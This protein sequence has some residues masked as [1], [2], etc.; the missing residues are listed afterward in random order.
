[1]FKQLAAVAAHTP[2]HLAITPQ[3]GGRLKVIVT[4]L[5]TGKAKDH[6]GLSKQFSATGTPEEL[7]AEFI[8]A[9]EQY[10]GKVNE[11]RA[12][13]GLPL[14][15]LDRIKESADKKKAKLEAKAAQEAEETKKREDAAKK[16]AETRAAKKAEEE[17]K[18]Q[19]AAERRAAKKAEKSKAKA[20][21]A[22]PGA[23]TEKADAAPFWPF[24]TGAAPTG[25]AASNGNTE[26]PLPAHLASLPGKPEVLA[27][28][29]AMR[30][31]HGDKA[32]KRKFFIK[33]SETGR[34]YEKLWETWADFMAEVAQ[35]T[36]PLATTEPVAATPDPEPEQE[37]GRPVAVLDSKSRTLLGTYSDDTD[38]GLIISIDGRAGKFAVDSVTH[39]VQILAH[40]V[41]EKPYMLFDEKGLKL[42]D[43]GEIY[44]EGDHV[45][46]LEGDW[47]VVS[48]QTHDGAYTVR[49][50][51][52]KYKVYT[53][54]DEFLIEYKHAPQVGERLTVPDRAHLF[55][56]LLI[57]DHRVMARMVLP[58]KNRLVD[59][60]SGEHLGHTEEIYDVTDQVVELA[61]KDYR[62]V[63][64]DL[65]AYHLKLSKPRITGPAAIATALTE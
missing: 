42:G 36:L 46:E 22:L 47:R 13:I 19:E 18:A 49:D 31:K 38:A 50:A 4:P 12:E 27:D 6:A 32:L 37:L 8:P 35:L 26:K 59:H 30:A 55:K 21:I 52:P 39:G 7:D 44:V 48:V 2:L 56:V 20:G 3:D 65:D 10:A 9:L 53:E 60:A 58:T 16:G 15:E 64:V 14:A 1:M 34:R 54:D 43:A 29:K 25:V 28:F 62:V 24:P 40:E 45:A 63:K 17:R 51:A 57:D 11:V 23:T 41:L 5:P 33:R 61:P